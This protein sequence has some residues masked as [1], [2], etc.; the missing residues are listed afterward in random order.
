[1][2]LLAWARAVVVGLADV[3][4]ECGER[5]EEE[6]ASELL[7]SALGGRLPGMELSEQ[8]V[9]EGR[10]AY[11]PDSATWGSTSPRIDDHVAVWGPNGLD[12]L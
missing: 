1:M 12:C 3:F 9:I 6:G 8:R 11:S 7:V 5:G 10:P 4:G 2:W